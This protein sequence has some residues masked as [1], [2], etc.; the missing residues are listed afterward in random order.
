YLLFSEEKYCKPRAEA[1]PALIRP[2]RPL[3]PLLPEVKIKTF[4]TQQ[5]KRTIFILENFIHLQ[6]S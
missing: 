4:P 1:K 2:G 6:K 3:A 5:T